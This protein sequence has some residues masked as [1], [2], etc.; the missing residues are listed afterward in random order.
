MDIEGDSDAHQATIASKEHRARSLTFNATFD[1]VA[2]PAL[3]SA[4]LEDHCAEIFVRAALNQT[5]V[6]AMELFSFAIPQTS[7]L[8]SFIDLQ[9]MAVTGALNSKKLLR[10]RTVQT[11]F[12]H[13]LEP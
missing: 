4:G 2:H 11:L 13:Q 3:V 1:L 5:G 8:S 6:D 7:R 9:G 10:L 12:R